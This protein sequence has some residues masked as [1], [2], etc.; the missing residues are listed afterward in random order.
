MREL[1]TRIKS[2][3]T[4][5]DKN[6]I[7]LEDNIFYPKGGGQ[8]GDKGILIIDGKNIQII[9]TLKDQYSD[10]GVLIITEEQVDESNVGK[11]VE[12]SL[13]WDFRYNQMK[14]H[15]S[16]HLH[17]CIIERVAGKKMPY[18]QV[19]SIEETGFAFNRYE[20]KEITEELIDKANSEFRK[21]ISEGAEVTTYPDA[22]KAGF[23][24]W[25]CLGYK[26]PCGGTHVKDISEIGEVSIKYSTKKGKPTVKITLA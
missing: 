7:Q 15:T 13:D 11:D 22:E 20:S 9:D 6:C 5:D 16:V 2:I 14:L 26:I 19:S 24:W 10:D 18:P 17:H 12:C 4:E 3:F 8:R 1:R 21:V 25:E 23:R